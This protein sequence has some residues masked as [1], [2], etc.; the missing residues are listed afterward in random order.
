MLK[1]GKTYVNIFVVSGVDWIA[2]KLVIYQQK[3]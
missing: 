1:N 2:G 3:T